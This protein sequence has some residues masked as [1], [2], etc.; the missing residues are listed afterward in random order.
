MPNC[1]AERVDNMSPHLIRTRAHPLRALVLLIAL[2]VGAW[3]AFGTARP[4][5]ATSIV[6][7]AAEA[8]DLVM[9]RVKMGAR[10]NARALELAERAQREATHY[11][12]VVALL[13]AHAALQRVQQQRVAMWDTL[14]QCETQQNWSLVGRYGGGLGIYVGAWTEFGGGEFASNPGYASKEQQIIVA[15]RIYARY[16]LDGWGCAHTLGWVN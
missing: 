16:G 1:W 5:R 10:A 15:E 8:R 6:R 12:S 13:N 3:S 11:W 9:Q 4:V 7:P 2:G 14:A